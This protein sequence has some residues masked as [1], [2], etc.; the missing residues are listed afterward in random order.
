MGANF[1]FRLQLVRLRPH[2]GLARARLFF[3]TEKK[4]LSVPVLH[5]GWT[6]E[7]GAGN[8]GTNANTVLAVGDGTRGPLLEEPGADVMNDD[9][10]LLLL[11]GEVN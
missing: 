10:V 4:K 9:M 5:D 3:S 7:H 2:T 8:A 6:R 11:D 1:S